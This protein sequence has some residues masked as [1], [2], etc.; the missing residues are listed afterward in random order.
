V[1]KLLAGL[2]EER[3]AVDGTLVEQTLELDHSRKPF[4]AQPRP[5]GLDSKRG[6][7]TEKSVLYDILAKG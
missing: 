6:C 1:S 3:R 7:R 5:S 2:L 4:A